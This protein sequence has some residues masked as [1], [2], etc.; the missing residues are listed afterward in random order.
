VLRLTGS[1]SPLE[2]RALPT[3]DP[4]VRQPDIT[5]ARRELGW[6]PMV[7]LDEG[8]RHTIAYFRDRLDA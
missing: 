5:V 4:K 1:R 6:D 7:Q 8:L 3:D 2:C